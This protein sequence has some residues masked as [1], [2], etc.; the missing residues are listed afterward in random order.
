M[1]G[2][3]LLS[4]LVT[5]GMTGYPNPFS[6]SALNSTAMYRKNTYAHLY[7]KHSHLSNVQI[8]S[9]Y[10]YTHD[11]QHLMSIALNCT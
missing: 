10:Y 6:P 5:F 1:L 4:E 11:M 9:I 2:L 7:L 8:F 3:K